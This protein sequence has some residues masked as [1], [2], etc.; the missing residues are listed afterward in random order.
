M[1]EYLHCSRKIPDS[2][3]L[4]NEKVITGVNAHSFKQIEG[5]SSALIIIYIPKSIKNIYLF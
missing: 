5:I 4:L 3:D 1:K 2:F